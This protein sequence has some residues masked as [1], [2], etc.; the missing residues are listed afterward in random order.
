MTP[1]KNEK[2]TEKRYRGDPHHDEQAQK[3]RHTSSVINKNAMGI[4]RSLAWLQRRRLSV[5]RHGQAQ[6]GSWRWTDV[7]VNARAGSRSFRARH[8][9]ACEIT[10]DKDDVTFLRL[11]WGEGRSRC[12]NGVFTSTPRW[13]SGLT[14]TKAMWCTS[15]SAEPRIAGWCGETR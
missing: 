10:Q 6:R 14:A 4:W 1:T 3:R 2:A 9:T 12:A 8:L 11:F 15:C 13:I 7:C 5:L